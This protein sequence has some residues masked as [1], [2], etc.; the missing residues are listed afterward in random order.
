MKPIP[1]WE[2]GSGV[3]SLTFFP[4]LGMGAV[5]LLEA[6]V[7]FP[8]AVVGMGLAVAL[9]VA[10]DVALAVMGVAVAL[11]DRPVPDGSGS[12]SSSRSGSCVVR[13]VFRCVVRLVFRSVVRSV[14]RLVFRSV[15]RSV[16]SEWSLSR[17]LQDSQQSL[18]YPGME[19]YW[20]NT[21]I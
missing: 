10:L 3:E 16:V 14:F 9:D 21:S 2:L 7:A 6:M 18:L 19:Q 13:S 11:V 20:A 15:V 12:R 17:L 1:V 4:A 8:K 5:V